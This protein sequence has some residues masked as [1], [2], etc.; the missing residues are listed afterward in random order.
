[1][2][3]KRMQICLTWLL[4]ACMMLTL[5]QFAVTA[6]ANDQVSTAD[7]LAYAE[8]VGVLINEFRAENGLQP[9]QLAPVLL[10]VASVRSQELTALYSHS[11]PDGTDWFTAVEETKLDPNCYAAENIAAGFETPEAV[12]EGWKNSPSHRAAMLGEYYQY[13]GVSVT[14]LA[15]DPNYYFS[16]WDLI[17]ISAEVPPEGAWT[18]GETE[19]L[20]TAENTVDSEIAVANAKAALPGDYNEDGEVSVVDVVML[21]QVLLEQITPNE[22]QITQMDC[23]QDGVINQKDAA[24]LMQYILGDTSAI[25]VKG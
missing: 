20:F 19:D 9:V 1:M 15:D 25:P 2:M 8:E 3:K 10:D 13:I 7:E 21:Q 12:V 4:T 23:Y 18:P 24:V 16:Y 14:Y 11:R 17:L 5:P 6:F 22:Q